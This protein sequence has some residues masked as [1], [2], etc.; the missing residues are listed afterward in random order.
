MDMDALIAAD[1]SDAANAISAVKFFVNTNM[2]K[3]NIYIAFA[4]AGELSNQNGSLDLDAAFLLFDAN[5]NA[6]QE[7]ARTTSG[8]ATG[9]DLTIALDADVA[10]IQSMLGAVAATALPAA[11]TNWFLATDVNVFG[12]DIMV[13]GANA[14]TAPTLA[15]AYTETV[16]IT[17]ATTY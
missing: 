4:N 5:L 2:P 3:W 8:I 12:V 11:T 14:A 16:Y 9:G 10:T 1:G 7:D 17:L 15:G 6:W 13:A